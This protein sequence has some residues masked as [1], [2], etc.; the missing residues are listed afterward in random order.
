MKKVL[1]IISFFLVSGLI[2]SQEK[3]EIR[4]LI[5]QKNIH[6]SGFG[7]PMMNITAIN[8]EFAFMMGGGGGI[9]L[10]DFFIGGYGMGLAT[11]IPYGNGTERLDFGYGGL[12]IG[13]NIKAKKMIHPAVHLQLGWGNI[14]RE[15][16]ETYDYDPD[17]VFVITP[18]LEMELNV[19]R[20]FKFGIGAC[21]S[22]VTSVNDPNFSSV[23][24]NN[25]GAFISFK[26]G[27]F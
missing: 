5:G 24:F 25:P 10:N 27:G 9:M 2:Y 1:I 12:W 26:F 21:Y 18:A 17:N 4:T 14:S 11:S 13:Y 15:D 20:F 19:T 22:I 7:G 16:H 6:F 3:D 8:G 23:D